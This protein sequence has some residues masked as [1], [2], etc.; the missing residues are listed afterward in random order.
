[1]PAPVSPTND[2][3]T[4]EPAARVAWLESEL[5]GALSRIAELT[6]ERDQL[7]AS[8]DRLWVEV[9]LMRRRLFVAKAERIDATQ[10][11]LEFKDKL[12]ALD[13]LAGTLGI[14]SPLEDEPGNGTRCT[15]P[16]LPSVTPDG[17]YQGHGGPDRTEEILA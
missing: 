13:A 11:E 9:E 7:R 5:A 16:V 1:M 14:D 8:Y 17:Q 3:H 12:A 6:R 4:D 15:A 2:S 10:L